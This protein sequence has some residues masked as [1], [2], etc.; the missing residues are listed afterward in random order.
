MTRKNTR[1]KSKIG[2]LIGMYLMSFCHAW[3]ERDITVFFASFYINAER[4][5]YYEKDLTVDGIKG[6]PL[7]QPVDPACPILSFRK[8]IYPV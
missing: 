3:P 6:I 2:C 1:T 7:V 5:Q 8:K 4:I